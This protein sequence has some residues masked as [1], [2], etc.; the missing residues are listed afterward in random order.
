MRIRDGGKWGEGG[1]R[2]GGGRVMTYCHHKNDSCIRMGSNKSHF[3]ASLIVRDKV[4]R[5]CPQTTTILKSKVCQS[6]IRP[7]PSVYQPKALPLGQTGSQPALK[8]LGL[9]FS[10]K[11][12]A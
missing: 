3:N 12:L 2:W 4:T 8:P 9:P 11:V 10:S 5:Q 1:M 7:R 6:G